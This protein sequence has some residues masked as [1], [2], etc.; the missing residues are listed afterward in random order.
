MNHHIP[1]LLFRL[2]NEIF[3]IEY[4]SVHTLINVLKFIIIRHGLSEPC[5][6]SVIELILVNISSCF[7]EII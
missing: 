2:R 5:V 7:I 1:P 6:Y 3:I 4:T